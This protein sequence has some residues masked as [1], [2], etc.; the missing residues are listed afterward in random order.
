M[1]VIQFSV[2]YTF[3]LWDNTTQVYKCYSGIL[4]CISGATLQVVN[5]IQVVQYYTSDTSGTMYDERVRNKWYNNSQKQNSIQI[6]KYHND[7]HGT[8]FC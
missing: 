7:M 4:H 2:R 5:I 1:Q 6:Y 3:F 8:Q